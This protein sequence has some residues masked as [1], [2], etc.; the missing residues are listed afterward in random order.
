M[1]RDSSIPRN[2]SRKKAC[3]LDDLRRLPEG[4]RAELLGGQLCRKAEPSKRH[5]ELQAVLFREVWECVRQQEDDSKP[6]MGPYAVYLYADSQNYVEPDISVICDPRKFT[7]EG[8]MGAPDWI[9][10]ITEPDSRSMDYCRKLFQYKRAGVR[11]YWIADEERDLILVYDL[12]HDTA[13]NYAFSEPVPVGIYP[14]Y[15]I[16][17]PERTEEDG[18]KDWGTGG[19]S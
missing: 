16:R 2:P 17:I 3:N 15:S 14:G 13:E 5:R 8:C 4:E 9:I 10:E 6:Y 1:R 19:H 18:Q 11:E 12:Q 7:D